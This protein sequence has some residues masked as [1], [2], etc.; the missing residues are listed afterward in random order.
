[1]KREYP[2]GPIP[3]VAAVVFRGSK[4]LLARRANEPSKGKWTLPGGVIELGEPHI[5]A[6]KREVLEETGIEIDVKALVALIDRIVWDKEGRPKYH[7]MIL[8]YWAEY[9]KGTPE[10]ASDVSAIRWAEIGQIDSFG[11]TSQAQG[12]I[13]KAWE[14]KRKQG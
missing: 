3:A 7:Y 6:L 10:P 9:R 2:T 8:D 14:M 11:L 12:V 5:D 13:T 4:V 1:M